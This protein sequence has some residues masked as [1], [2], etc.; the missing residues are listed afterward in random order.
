MKPAYSGKTTAT[1]SPKFPV[2]AEHDTSCFH[3]ALALWN[4]RYKR[5]CTVDELTTGEMS[6]VLSLA[7]EIEAQER[8]CS[9]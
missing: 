4:E 2:D 5:A 1:L 3:R 6:A 9:H 8:P 7:Q